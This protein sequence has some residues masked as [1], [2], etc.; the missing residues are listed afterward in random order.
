[1]ASAYVRDAET[2]EERQEAERYLEQARERLRRRWAERAATSQAAALTAD[3][4]TAWDVAEHDRRHAEERTEAYEQMADARWGVDG[5]AADRYDRLAAHHRQ[6][7]AEAK[8]TQDR[9]LAGARARRSTP[10]A[11]APVARVELTAEQRVTIST[12]SQWNRPDALVTGHQAAAIVGED[13]AGRLPVAL[14]ADTHGR[15]PDMHRFGDVA[16]VAGDDLP[17]PARS[18]RAI[19][20]AHTRW[21]RSGESERVAAWRELDARRNRADL[22]G[23]A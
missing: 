5:S 22:A 20:Q 14:E 9:I 12:W 2:D 13:A 3:E 16:A 15:Y 6:A 7:A 17:A 10:A 18:T 23:A 19:L 4:Q 1:M 11:P 21:L 8:A